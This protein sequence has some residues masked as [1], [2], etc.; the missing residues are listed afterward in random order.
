MEMR[1]NSTLRAL[2]AKYTNYFSTAKISFAK[3]NHEIHE[4][5]EFQVRFLVLVKKKLTPFS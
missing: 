3:L 1:R 5:H 4:I 2:S